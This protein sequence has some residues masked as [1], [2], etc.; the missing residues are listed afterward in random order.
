[1]RLMALVAAVIAGVGTMAWAVEIPHIMAQSPWK[2]FCGNEAGG[3]VRVCVTRAE[4]FNRE[5]DAVQVTFDVVEREGRRTLR[6]IFPLGVQLVHGTRLVFYGSDP[7][8]SRYAV[9]HAWG[10]ISEYVMTSALAEGLATKQAVVVQAIDQSG[11]PQTFPVSLA[12]LQEALDAAK[13]DPLTENPRSPRKPWLDDTLRPE[14][15][16]ARN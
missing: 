10:C 15:R 3:S 12:G 6:V 16:P 7:W 11:R 5:D 13:A 2:K 14:L 8:R 9:C 4:I 1:M